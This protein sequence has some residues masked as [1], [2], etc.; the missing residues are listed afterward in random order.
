MKQFREPLPSVK[1]RN[2]LQ[3]HLAL[4]LG[5]RELT[6]CNRRG[7]LV[8]YWS[9][10]F[11]TPHAFYVE[12]A[13][14]KH[15]NTFYSFPFCSVCWCVKALIHHVVKRQLRMT[16]TT[17]LGKIKTFQAGGKLWESPS[18][19][20]ISF[21]IFLLFVLTPSH[22]AKTTNFPFPPQENES[23]KLWA[24]LFFLGWGRRGAAKDA[25]FS[26]SFPTC[27]GNRGFLRQYWGK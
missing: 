17:W 24:Q 4:S 10:G 11:S 15:E 1:I 18:Q 16:K 13:R 8:Q 12:W 5:C 2:C 27:N 3:E 22:S 7:H 9:H 20:Y 23:G 6:S 26:C 19:F 25:Q 14:G 21:R